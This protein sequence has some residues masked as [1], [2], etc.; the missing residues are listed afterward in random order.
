MTNEEFLQKL[1]TNFNAASIRT[2]RAGLGENEV[3]RRAALNLIHA[4]MFYDVS[5]I[6]NK[7]CHGITPYVKATIFNPSNDT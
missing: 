3:Y 2:E 5:V 4:I 7:D 6:F 1:E